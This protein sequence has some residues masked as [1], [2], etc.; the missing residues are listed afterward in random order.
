MWVDEGGRD[1][2]RDGEDLYEACWEGDLRDVRYLV[3]DEGVN[4]NLTGGDGHTTG[5]Q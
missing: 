2:L 1:D 4:P 5:L 3:E